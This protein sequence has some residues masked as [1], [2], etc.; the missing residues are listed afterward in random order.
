[1]EG[2][3]MEHLL[4]TGRSVDEICAA[5]GLDGADA[6]GLAAPQ[7]LIQRLRDDERVVD[8]I[9]FLAHALPKR[10]AIWWAWSC[11]RHAAGDDP[12][13]AIR[14][15]LEAT[16]LWIREPS[17][18]H[19]RTAY[20][21]AQKADLATAAGCAGAAAFFSGGSMA[22]ADQPAMPPEEFMSAK[23]ISGSVTLAALT[24]PERAMA[25]M[26]EYLDRGLEVAERV[27]LWQAPGA[28]GD[29]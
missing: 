8:A 28:G 18:A 14:D 21:L 9:Q 3:K 11:A 2:A 12:P 19:R 17:D 26:E 1:M 22:P 25:Q 29:R 4:G 20:E 7:E 13:E 5:A 23:A 27:H 10:E 16:G 15:S 6:E 24:E